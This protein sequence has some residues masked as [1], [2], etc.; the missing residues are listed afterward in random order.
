MLR[1][2]RWPKTNSLYPCLDEAAENLLN[3]PLPWTYGLVVEL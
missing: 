3:W 2:H 1:F